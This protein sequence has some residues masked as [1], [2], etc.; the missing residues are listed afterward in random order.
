MP[1]AAPTVSFRPMLEADLPLL[2]EWIQR[3]HVAEWWGGGL[4][5]ESLED[6]RRKYLPR[7]EPDFPVKGY[8]ALLAGE[9]LGFIQ[10]YVAVECGDG[11]WEDE[12]DPGVRGIDQFLADGSKLGQGLGS[13]L[14]TAFVRNLFH[15]PNVTKVQ[16]DPDPKNARAIRCYEKVGFRPLGNVTTPDG[17]ALLMAI[18]RRES[19]A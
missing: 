7:L 9:P 15:D 17:I 11:W 13:Q 8:I 1:E 10:S 18:A 4:I 3:P 5:G 19:V 16:A 14:V 12:T 2:H 6:T